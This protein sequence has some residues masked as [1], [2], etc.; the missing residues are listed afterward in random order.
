[1][2]RWFIIGGAGFLGSHLV[3]HLLAD[4][5]NEVLVSDILHPD[6]AA[7]IARWRDK[8]QYKWQSTQDIPV[9][10]LSDI[11]FVI[12]CAAQADVALALSSPHYTFQQNVLSLVHVLEI[13]R[14]TGTDTTLIYTSSYDAYG[15]VPYEHIPVT[16]DEALRPANPYGVSK[17]SADL[18]CQAY[19]KTFGARIVILRCS[20][21][22]GPRARTTQVIPMFINRALQNKDLNVE[23]DGSQTGDFNYVSQAVEGI[24]LTSKNGRSG[25]VYNLGSGQETSILSLAKLI[26]AMTGSNAEIIFRP[27][28]KGE[29]GKRLVLSIAK[30]ERE[31]GYRPTIP[32]EEGLKRTIDW[33]KA[34]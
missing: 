31:L 26:I 30:A 6:G 29:Q 9:S 12:H 19:A 2:P 22:F 18:L 8:I 10:D 13:L 5:S 3:E 33:F 32:L 21:I 16:E 1:M 28:R 20:A 4:D 23:G 25:E 27:W 7:K 15:I 17:A 14:N 11:D 24:M 34:T